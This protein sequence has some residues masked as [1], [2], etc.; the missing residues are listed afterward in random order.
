MI[1]LPISADT[2]FN[3]IHV[4]DVKGSGS[5][6]VKGGGE[7]LSAALAARAPAGILLMPPWSSV[8]QRRSIRETGRAHLL[9]HPAEPPLWKHRSARGG[10][11]CLI[12]LT[13]IITSV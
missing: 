1:V 5:R 9:Q 3:L 8:E 12:S 2:Y 10:A 7:C 13:C 6:A 11:G 4:S